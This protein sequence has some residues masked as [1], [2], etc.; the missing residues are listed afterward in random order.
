MFG[1]HN[2]S[3][4][5][6][7]V[8]A[9]MHMRQGMSNDDDRISDPSWKAEWSQQKSNKQIHAADKLHATVNVRHDRHLCLSCSVPSNL[10]MNCNY[11][12]ALKA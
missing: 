7:T 4:T 11:I 12:K 8:A 6:N 3:N 2:I 9:S 1:R 5:A 10:G